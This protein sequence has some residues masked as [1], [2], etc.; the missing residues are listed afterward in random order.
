MFDFYKC[1]F[2]FQY[3]IISSNEHSLSILISNRPSFGILLGSNCGPWHETVITAG[4]KGG[5]L[6][7]SHGGCLRWVSL[8]QK[9]LYVCARD[10]SVLVISTSSCQ[11]ITAIP[12]FP[13]SVV[14]THAFSFPLYP[15][16]FMSTCVYACA[17]MYY[18]LSFLRWKILIK[19]YITNT[20]TYWGCR[21]EV[22]LRCRD[23]CQ[24]S[25]HYR[26]I[27]CL[28]FLFEGTTVTVLAYLVP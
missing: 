14:P 13:D 18:L 21:D 7:H 12:L 17:I 27:M 28:F 26:A 11:Q 6:A 19:T 4:V 15:C 10:F 25:V 23:S 1:I 5:R 9:T 22:I 16:A 24:I 2:F 20:C 8:E 3:S